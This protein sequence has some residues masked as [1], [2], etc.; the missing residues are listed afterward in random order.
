MEEEK[1]YE[2][3]KLRAMLKYPFLGYI[4]SSIPVMSSSLA[5]QAASTDGK[6]IYINP[7]FFD[8]LTSEQ[9]LFLYLHEVLHIAFGHIKR[10]E[11]KDGKLWNVATDAVINEILNEDNVQPLENCIRKEGAQKLTAEEVYAMLL[12]E[13]R[14]NNQDQKNGKK[15]QQGSG[16]NRNN[17]TTRTQKDSDVD[18]SDKNNN[19]EQ[20]GHD[21]HN[22][23]K[24][25]I[26]TPED[27][28]NA[29]MCEQMVKQALKS[30]GNH[31][32]ALSRS[33]DGL[34]SQ[35]IVNWK[36][37][38][39]STFA[40]KEDWS[41]RGC[42][43]E[44]GVLDPILLK[45]PH[46]ST[47]IV[48]D[49][50]GSVSDELIY[51]FLGEVKHMLA[52]TDV[53]AGCFDTAFYGFQNITIDNINNFKIVGRGGTDFDVAVDAFTK[54]ANNKIV[55]TDGYAPMPKLS[56]KTIWVVVGENKIEPPGGRVVHITEEEVRRL[57]EINNNAMQR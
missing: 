18:E 47:E 10:R 36:Y 3:T 32:L 15:K 22:L 43:I 16:N 20:V 7:N 30:Y 21:S 13:D 19:D 2:G 8:R 25:A 49:T 44:N 51:I 53:K 48:I 9:K 37:F 27:E 57:V 35:K 54:T 38:L 56:P 40:K 55:F 24:D 46:Y 6:K 28:I 29:E 45:K 4:I 41:R 17:S 31:S 14:E 34:V 12:K 26:K 33:I 50:S 39:K 23:W 5:E 11:N 52:S 42:E 1:R